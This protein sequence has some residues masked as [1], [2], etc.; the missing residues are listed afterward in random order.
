MERILISFSI[1]LGPALLGW[2][3][4]SLLR[5]VLRRRFGGVLWPAMLLVA[6]VG[7]AE[8]LNTRDAFVGIWD[9]ATVALAA[10]VGWVWALHRAFADARAMGVAALSTALACLLVEGLCR[11]CLGPAP[12]FPDAANPHLLLSAAMRASVATRMSTTNCQT[13]ACRTIY[14]AEHAP[15][16]PNEPHAQDF[17][18]NPAARLHVLHVGD[19]VAAGSDVD[20]RFT[21]DLEALEPAIE[22]INAAIGATATDT[23]LAIA[24]RWLAL[25]HI[26]AVVIHVNPNDAKEMDAPLPCTNWQSLLVYDDDGPRLRHA[27]DHTPDPKRW[28]WRLLLQNSPP[29]YLLRVGVEHSAAAAHLA[30]AFVQL[31]RQAALDF[32]PDELRG[33]AHI[34]ACLAALRDELA[35]RKVA[36]VVDVLHSTA[37]GNDARSEWARKTA[38]ALGIETID[39]H[40]TLTAAV[41]RGAQPY[42]D[43]SGHFNDSGHAIMARWLHEILGPAIAR[44]RHR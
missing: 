18:P 42:L 39:G 24:W 35:P 32:V 4:G 15:W 33:R 20:G 17:R 11:L 23:Q 36:L 34:R 40:A 14:L 25:Q 13:A 5:L 2:L 30:A 26:D 27:S 22:H 10:V 21:H 29:P 8:W 43:S 16:D 9:A 1:I 41:A 19:S 6:A 12:V 3:I 7:M 44:A 28:R 37:P 31:G 38:T